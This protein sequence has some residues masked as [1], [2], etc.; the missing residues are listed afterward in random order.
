MFLCMENSLTLL[1]LLSVGTSGV[2]IPAVV[3]RGRGLSS[4]APLCLIF[5]FCSTPVFWTSVP[6]MLCT[7]RHS[8]MIVTV[9]T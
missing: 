4:V 9:F 7:S 8:H 6:R 3:A 5:V 1:L 2:V